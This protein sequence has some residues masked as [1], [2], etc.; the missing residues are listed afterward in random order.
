M[1]HQTH[2][3]MTGLPL[4]TLLRMATVL[5]QSVSRTTL[6]NSAEETSNVSASM[7]AFQ[8]QRRCQKDVVHS[9]NGAYASCVI[10]VEWI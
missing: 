4:V 9:V 10:I 6:E 1:P 2:D 3:S 7:S 8:S 5:S